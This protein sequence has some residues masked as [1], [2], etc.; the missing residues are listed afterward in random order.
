M[1]RL[2]RRHAGLALGIALF[3][4]VAAAQ[5]QPQPQPTPGSGTT[6]GGRNT[7]TPTPMPGNIPG[8]QQQQPGLQQPMEQM[9][10][11]LSGRVMLEDGTPPGDQTIIERVCGG[12]ARPEAYTDTKGRFSFRVGENNGVF[13]DASIG[14]ANDPYGDSSRGTAGSRQGSPFGGSQSMGTQGR[15]L[16]GCELR[17]SLPG[18][19]SDVVDL[20][21]HRALD[22]PDVGVIIL[23]RL[24]NVQGSTISVSSML[25]PKEAQK[26]YGKGAEALKKSNWSEAQK[27]LEKAVEI[28]P[29][30][31]AAWS[32]LGRAYQNQ[33]NTAE[34]S[35]A[36]DKALEADPKYL[37]PYMHRAVLALNQKNW[38]EV[39]RISERLIELDPVDY[40]SAYLYDAL[41]QLNLRNL[42][43]AEKSALEGLKLD[44]AHRLPKLEHVL[45]IVLANKHDYAGAA[46]HLRGYLDLSPGASDAD[47]VRQQLVEIERRNVQ[48]SAGTQS[49]PPRN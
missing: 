47:T 39:A 34:A 16:M 36:F 27:Q 18:Y 21:G 3:A 8:Q 26:A 25:A 1:S 14:G 41:A 49:D 33:N 45:G 2:T 23:H 37:K 10:I 4:G 24:A 40:P 6:P 19:R 12:T 38:S 42:D 11:F 9:P 15:G 35:K 30:Y 7:P 43:A 20:M 31:A 13:Q 5:Q 29:L 22:H 17:A 46:G 48:S 44:T 28:Y 32:D